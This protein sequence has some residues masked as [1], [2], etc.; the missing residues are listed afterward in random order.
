MAKVLDE[1]LDIV[2]PY[3]AQ[4]A[5]ITADDIHK[6]DVFSEVVDCRDIDHGHVAPNVGY[7]IKRG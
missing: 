6:S 1:E 5:V 3:L 2:W 4:E 7:M